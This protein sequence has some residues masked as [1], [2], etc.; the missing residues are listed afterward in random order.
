[1]MFHSMGIIYWLYDMFTTVMFR[2]EED[3]EDFESHNPTLNKTRL[4]M[5][6]ASIDHPCR[7]RE[8]HGKFE[9]DLP[10]LYGLPC[11]FGV[12]GHTI[13]WNAW[14]VAMYFGDGHERLWTF[15]VGML[16]LIGMA[17]T[18]AIAKKPLIH[19]N[20]RPPDKWLVHW[21]GM[22]MGTGLSC[23]VQPCLCETICINNC[24]VQF[25]MEHAHC[26][27][28]WKDFVNS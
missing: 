18:I 23:D 14:F 1:M 28:L 4:L 15:T 2:F 8:T 13:M 10:P 3:K 20:R 7:A 17:I 21:L 9:F 6:S 16:L 24:V 11:Y 19:P 25:Y 22:T 12:F 5:S 27:I 26:A